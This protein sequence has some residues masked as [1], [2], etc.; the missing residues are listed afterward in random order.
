[1]VLCPEGEI[2]PPE[3]GTKGGRSRL[4]RA[5]DSPRT[6]IVCPDGR[7]IIPIEEEAVLLARHLDLR[8]VETVSKEEFA[9]F[10]VVTADQE[11]ERRAGTRVVDFSPKDEKPPRV[12]E[13]TPTWIRLEVDCKAPE[14]LVI[15]QAHYPGWKAR[16]NGIEKPVYRANYAFSAIEMQRGLNLVDFSY[17]PESFRLGL[18]IGLACG[19]CGLMCLF[20][21]PQE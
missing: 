3:D 7:W 11:F 21:H 16:V 8:N 14:F 2:A 10:E 6:Y 5:A 20:H 18:W 1:V 17:E 19:L 13:E 12:I 4:I 9:R 15:A